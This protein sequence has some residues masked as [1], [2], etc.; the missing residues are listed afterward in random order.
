MPHIIID[1]LNHLSG[2]ASGFLETNKGKRIFAFF[3]SMGSGKTTFIKSLC[4]HLGSLDTV[5]SP[6]FTIINEYGTSSGVSLYHFDFYRIEKA[7]EIFDVGFLE[8]LE[9]GDYCFMEWPE[10]IDQWLPGETVRVRISVDS[11]LKRH[12]DF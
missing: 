2:S 7:S 12:L 10:I 5:T 11:E 6:T 8:Y 4:E 3:G 9:S 1:D